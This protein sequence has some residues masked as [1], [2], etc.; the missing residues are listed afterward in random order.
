LRASLRLA[1]GKFD[2][3]LDALTRLARLAATYPEI[4]F[5]C[6]QTMVL[7][8]NDYVELWTNDIRTILETVLHSGDASLSAAASNLINELGSHGHDTYRLLLK[9]D[10]GS[11]NG[12]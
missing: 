6:A 3:V 7:A 10:F 4:V 8:A 11:R 12:G 1:N 2:P 5:E 9:P